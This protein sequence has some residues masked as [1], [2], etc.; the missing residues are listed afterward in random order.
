MSS[1]LLVE[2]DPQTAALLRRGVSQGL[3][4]CFAELA[5]AE[6]LQARLHEPEASVN[7][8]VLG[9][10]LEDPIRIAQGALSVNQE[11]AILILSH[12]D[13]CRQLKQ[14]LQFAPRAGGQV[15]CHSIAEGEAIGA[16]LEQVVNRVQRRRA[17]KASLAAANA[18]LSETALSRAPAAPY[19]D[20][21]LAVVPIGVLALD[22]QLLVL[23]SNRKAAE[24]LGGDLRGVLRASL[25]SFFPETQSEKLRSFLAHCHSAEMQGPP[26]IFSRIE[27][28]S[29]EQFLELTAVALSER[30][31]G[32]GTIVILQ[33]V[34]GWVQ[35]EGERE[36]ALR[37]RDQLLL[38]ERAARAK[39]K[40]VEQRFHD[41]VQDLEAIV[42]EA[43]AQT[44][45]FA[46]VSRR[47]EQILG[48]PVE[49]WLTE[50]NFW[51]NHVH[52][53][54]REQAVS[55]CV[56]ATSEG[57]NH[58]F[59]YRAMTA[60]GGVVWLQDFVHVSGEPNAPARR[61]RGVMVDITERKQAEIVLRDSEERYRLLFES[62]PN[63]A[64]VYDSETL[65]FLAVNQEAIRRYGYSGE[66]FRAMTLREIRPTEDV[67]LLVESLAKR[68]RTIEKAGPWRHRKKDGTLI[69]VETVSTAI[70]FE[71]R[72]A[73]LVLAIDITERKR[74][75]EALI[76]YS[77]EVEEARHRVELQAEQL[78][79]QSEELARARDAA[80]EASR[81]KSA[82]VAN[83]SHEIRTPM[84]GVIGM[85]G[86]LLDT[87]LGP[88]QREYA[89]TVRHSAEALLAIINDILDFSKIEAG[90]LEL[91][92]TDFDL[93]T[94]V[95]EVVD[96]LAE[97][98][99]EKGL[100][101]S[102][103]FPAA[104]PTA[105][106]GD[107]GRL[108]QVLTNLVGNAVKF[109]VAGEVILKVA[110]EGQ[111][112]E[113]VMMRFEVKDTGIGITRQARQRLFQA[114]TQADSST[115]R[116]F[117]GTGLGLTISKQLAELMGGEIGVESEP[118]KGRTFWFTAR[119]QTRPEFVT[120]AAG[121]ETA[122]K[123][124]RA[125]VV[126]DNATN[127][128]ILRHQLAAWGMHA[129]E[130]EDGPSALERLR[131]GAGRGEGYQL[132]LVDH[133]MPG[134]DGMELTRAIKADPA[135]AS[136]PV[137]MLTSLGS[138]AEAVSW[139]E[140]IS[141]WLTKPVRQSRL[142]DC[143]MNALGEGAR[144]PAPRHRGPDLKEVEV[145][146]RHRILVAEDNVVNQKV[147]VRML[148]KLGCRVDVAADGKEALEALRLVPYALVLMDCQMPEMDGYEATAAIRGAE[149]VTGSHIPIIAMTAHAMEGDREKC[150]EAGM[151]DYIAKP[152]SLEGL[153]KVLGRWLASTQ[154]PRS[155]KIP[156]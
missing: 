141:G 92:N 82:F 98:A 93:R 153:G 9:S 145:R 5:S 10:S 120:L 2:V 42:W 147:A 37:H 77:Q 76:R 112:G 81:L 154:Q 49:Q 31:G 155:D 137:V 122:L 23:T 104:A 36:E 134:M 15:L 80:L 19:L 143:V 47:A 136:L 59:E 125:L 6:E 16:E 69:D 68:G 130:V 60:D 25:L 21:L 61:L 38:S 41:L 3:R 117:G 62:N 151:D 57:K 121:S 100:E 111:T 101:L 35:A 148:E 78:I 51:V 12:P 13:R 88:E 146:F 30:D 105:L 63:P 72:K 90:K 8:L 129:D 131:A 40:A 66:E 133:Q 97:Q 29:Q 108:R 75:E 128:S 11:P 14:E 50:P 126:D 17:Y 91:E 110:V 113:A 39:A 96:L 107:P 48:Y 71:G 140:G 103:L 18:R 67:A 43:D 79:A 70:P 144:A 7:A 85:T 46:F 152:V 54:D 64:W 87:D 65:E 99:H 135:L 132:A 74:N 45:Q 34:T 94:A 109:T 150:L 115:T 116:K 102:C 33:D 86:L 83:M 55:F 58:S 149:R 32:P 89:E 124:L 22:P 1:I 24:M 4:D 138:R 95:E 53:D 27:G 106:R 156:S 73:R 52:P 44:W 20:R 119:L 123:G 84:N 127:R 139:P 118:G 114:F 26:E 56:Q 28:N 142:L